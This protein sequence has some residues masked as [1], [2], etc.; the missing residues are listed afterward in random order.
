MTAETATG[1]RAKSGRFAPGNPGKPKGARNKATLAA[2]ALLDGEAEA[3]TKK[4][5]EV[6]KTG[7]PKALK[8]CIE[9][10]LA[11]RRDRPVSFKLSPIK[12]A[13]DHPRA[14]AQILKAVAAGEVTPMEGQGLCQMLD[15]HRSSLATADLA[16]RIAAL[17]EERRNG[18]G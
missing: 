13:G 18:A 10:I 17:E 16:E 4:A 1:P 8:L 2:E 14:L 11:P 6:A 15:N 7:D 3:L 9:R 5:I 12:S